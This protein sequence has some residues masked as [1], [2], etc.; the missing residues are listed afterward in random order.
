MMG[1][2]SF[3]GLLLLCALMLVGCGGASVQNVRTPLQAGA[4]VKASDVFLVRAA[5]SQRTVFEGDGADEP[6][7]VALARETIRTGM[8][9]KIIAALRANGYRADVFPEGAVPPPNGIV[10]SL[11]ATT[12]DA[13]S[14]AARALVGFGSGK[15]F[16]NV[17]VQM[18]KGNAVIAAFTLDATS[19]GR[20]GWTAMGDWLD[21]H[22]D[23]SARLFVEYVSGEAD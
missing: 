4:V 13:G 16:L 15:S 1:H 3:K 7:N 20:S 11:V 6:T 19:G 8:S 22:I 23:D 17:D 14:K 2:F 9:N 21:T 18:T 12:F 10:V 5:D